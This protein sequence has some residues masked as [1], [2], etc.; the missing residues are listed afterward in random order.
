MYHHEQNSLTLSLTKCKLRNETLISSLLFPR[1]K[2]H[3]L[4]LHD[5]TIS[6]TDYSCQ[7]SFFEL[8]QAN[9]KVSL[10][11]TG[12]YCAMNHWLSQSSSYSTLLTDMILCITEQDSSTDETL[13]G[14]GL[15]EQNNL[16]TLSLKGCKLSSKTTSSLIHSLQSPHCKLHKISLNGCVIL[17]VNNGKVSLNATGS[18]CAINHWLSQLSSYSVTELILSITKQESA[19]TLMGIGL[20]SHVL[21]ILSINNN[22][23][24]CF[25]FS[26]PLFYELRQNNLHALSLTKCKLKSE[27]TSSLIHSLLSADYKLNKLALDECVTSA[28]DYTYQFSFFELQQ[29][30]GRFSLNATGSCCAINHCLSLFSP[31]SKLLTDMNLNITKQDSSTD[32]LLE[33]IG[34][35][36]HEQNSLTLSL[37]K[38]K[39]SNEALI[40]SLLF[41]HCKLHKL[42]LRDCTISTTDRSCQFSFFELQQANAKVSLNATGSYCAMNHWLSQSSS[43]STLLTDMTLCIT[44][45]DSSTDETLE[46]IGL[47]EQNN[48]HTLS[49][50]GCKL[51]TSSII[52]PLQSPH[53]KLHRF[54]LNDC[55]IFTTDHTYQFSTLTLQVNNGKVSLNAT[56]S[57]CAINHWLSQLSSYSVLL[58]ELILSITKQ[59]TDET[60][61][62][63]GLFSNLLEILNINNN[64]TTCFSFSVPL[65]LEL[66]Q[67]NLHT[68][69]LTKCKLNS[70]ATNS[71]FH[72]LLSPD[73]R[74]HNVL[75]DECITST[76]DHTYQFSFFELQ[77][78]DGKFSL[79]ATGSCCAINH[80]LSLLPSYSVLLSEL[81]L[82]ITKQ[83]TDETLEGIG[84]FSHVLEILNINNNHTTCFSFSIPLFL[85]LRQKNLYTLSLTKCKLSSEATSSLIHTLLSP[86]YK[87]NKLALY[88]CAISF[89]D[90]TYTFSTF[91]VHN[92]NVSLVTECSFSD[93]DH[94]LSHLSSYTMLKLTEL[95]LDIKG[96]YSGETLER[97]GLY[98]D[99]LEIV[100]MNCG[101]TFNDSNSFQSLPFIGLQQNNLH[102]LSLSYR[103]LS[104]EA[105]SSL[106]HSLQSPHC[107]LHKLALYHCATT[108]RTLLTT[109]IVSSTTITHLLFIDFVIDTPSLTA[110]ASGLKQ[111]RT[112]EE[113]AF[114]KISSK[115]FTKD[116]FQLLIEGV[117]SSAV[118]KLWLHNGYKKLESDCQL[119][120]DDVVVEWYRYSDNVYEKW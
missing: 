107:R 46:G 120:R 36:H 42:S 39:L 115:T 76:T 89:G 56:G 48:L 20:F 116:Q 80:W 94:W 12:S 92:C 63:I 86:D 58:S 30:N 50:K 19:E 16:H 110:L 64:H 102:T 103:W 32:E 43:Y 87:L 71:L 37:T 41:P 62:G 24:T 81:I 70:E 4:S 105:T 101:K 73:C 98:C 18:C 90:H 117:D 45:Q 22:H 114:D 66:R 99:V 118:K 33:E 3:K 49:L 34:L 8:Q 88:Q 113:L 54:S 17:Q 97:I 77:Q 69:S 44:E 21:E 119:S 53:C 111:N 25:S 15:Y 31:Y 106:I 2:L 108:D 9:A 26:V 100:K 60:L 47:Y 11:A 35:Y 51:S 67:N 10:N 29:T 82:S 65:F 95:I 93:I 75:L 38:C 68:L 74:L 28:T 14:I 85:E 23:T 78:T 91:K 6:T 7:F 79:N 112:M 27:A 61:E 40:S 59:E 1:C 96:H 104:S 72:S 57:C 109:A 5:C 55:V 13:E 84:L 52:H 83:E